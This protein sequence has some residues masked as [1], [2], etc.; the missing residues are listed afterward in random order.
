MS[1]MFRLVTVA[2]AIALLSA[3]AAEYLFG[4]ENMDAL[5]GV[6]WPAMLISGC[7][8]AFLNYRKANEVLEEIKE[9][10]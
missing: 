9:N 4:F 8:A 6:L 10:G 5:Q 2:V 1:L 7:L 3:L